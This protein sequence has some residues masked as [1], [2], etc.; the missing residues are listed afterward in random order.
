[1]PASVRVYVDE[2][3]KPSHELTIDDS[4]WNFRAVKCELLRADAQ[5]RLNLR[6]EIDWVKVDAFDGDVESYAKAVQD[7]S[8]ERLRAVNRAPARASKDAERVSVDMAPI[9]ATAS[10]TSTG[11]SMRSNATATEGR[12]AVPLVRA[13]PPT[14]HRHSSHQSQSSLR[15]CGHLHQC[16]TFRN[17]QNLGQGVIC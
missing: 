14:A 13:A 5:A 8:L 17:H 4:L 6:E 11:S 7:A 2:S 9:P 3:D 15:S 1:M 16:K 12:A 10:A